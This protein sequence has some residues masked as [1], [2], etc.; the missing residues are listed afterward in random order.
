[1]LYNL[2]HGKLP[3]GI[4]RACMAN[5]LAYMESLPLFNRETLFGGTCA[6]A[7]TPGDEDVV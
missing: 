4:D 6:F 7:A 5:Q 1:M 2:F 3:T